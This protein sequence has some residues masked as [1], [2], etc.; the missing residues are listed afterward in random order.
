MDWEIWWSVFKCDLAIRGAIIIGIVLAGLAY[1]WKT[2][3]K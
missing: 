1:L 2:W 3:E